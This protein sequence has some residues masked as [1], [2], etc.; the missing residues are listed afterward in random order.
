MQDRNKDERPAKLSFGAAMKA[1]FWSFF[2]VRKRSAYERDA[3]HLNPVYVILAGLL[4][5]AI[6]IAVLIILVKIAVAA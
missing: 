4:G 3:A 2:G 5:V 1:V 6:F